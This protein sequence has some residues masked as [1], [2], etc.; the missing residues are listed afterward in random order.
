[1]KGA[2]SAELKCPDVSWDVPQAADESAPANEKFP[3]PNSQP[4]T[5]NYQRSAS[6]HRHHGSHLHFLWRHLRLIRDQPAQERNQHD[7]RDADHQAARAE[8]GE[9]LHILGVSRDRGGALRIGDHARAITGE[10]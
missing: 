7:E 4:S 9:E 6:R 10:E 3:Y 8:L 1:M 5:T 2:F